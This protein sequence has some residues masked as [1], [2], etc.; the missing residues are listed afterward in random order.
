MTGGLVD[1]WRGLPG[2][3]LAKY[4]F[5][6]MASLGLSPL[7][8]RYLRHDFARNFEAEPNM[9]P[10]V[11]IFPGAILQKSLGSTDEGPGPAPWAHEST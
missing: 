1:G 5:S 4:G 6:K 11:L 2:H 9:D 7:Q 10:K 8:L 3:K